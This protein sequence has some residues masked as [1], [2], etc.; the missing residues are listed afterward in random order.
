MKQQLTEVQKLQ[1]IAGILKPELKEESSSKYQDLLN[2]LRD[3]ASSGEI[4]NNDIS[5]INRELLSAR[6]KMFAS[7]RSPES[8]KAA[9][10]KAKSTKQ[11]AETLKKIKQ[12][13]EKEAMKVLPG[14][15]EEKKD[16]MILFHNKSDDAS[17]K[18]QAILKKYVKTYNQIF[19]KLAVEAGLY[20]SEKDIPK[21]ALQHYSEPGHEEPYTT[22]DPYG[23]TLRGTRYVSGKTH[24]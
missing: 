11:G 8:Y 9:A 23:R 22:E 14:T 12:E 5:S 20:K 19:K 2:Q 21:F 3:L 17:P 6:R 24:Y 1:K 10:E 18:Q 4:D 7:K 13:A 16:I 15:E